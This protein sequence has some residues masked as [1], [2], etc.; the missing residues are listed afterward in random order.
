MKL[1]MILLVILTVFCFGG[2]LFAQTGEEEAKK[3]VEAK[4]VEEVKDTTEVK[5]AEVEKVEGATVE[6]K[7]AKVV[8]KA[9]E[10]KAEVPEEPVE[11]TTETGLKYVDIKIGEGKSPK[12]GQ[13]VVVHYTG[14]LLDG[15]K[16]DSSVDRDKPFEFTIGVGQVIKGWD[17]GVMTMKV[18]GKRK[19]II[20]PELGYGSR[21]V[22]SVIPPNSTLIFEIELLG[23]K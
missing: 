18:G 6:K 9:E 5:E 11:I 1:T 13:V 10:K 2:M 3:T 7:G 19:L 8:K 12:K 16:F 20:P 14:T 22:G 23:I 17:E 15:K 4:K 21:S